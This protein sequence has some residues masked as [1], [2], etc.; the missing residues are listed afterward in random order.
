MMRCKQKVCC[1]VL[2]VILVVPALASALSWNELLPTLSNAELL[3]LQVLLNEELAGR[4]LAGSDGLPK[5]YMTVSGK[6]FHSD[7]K[8]SNM[9]NPR[10]VSLTDARSVGYEPCKKCYG[11]K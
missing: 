3:E 11:S 2:A 7:P 9:K 6:K 10:E 8:C 4:G 1:L 5:V